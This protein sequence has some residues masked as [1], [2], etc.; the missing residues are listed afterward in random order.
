MN[1]NEII[2]KFLEYQID[3]IKYET[4]KSYT[5][6]K[7]SNK[8]PKISYN[9]VKDETGSKFNIIIG[10]KYDKENNLPFNLEI[11]IRG[12]FETLNEFSDNE[13]LEI[14]VSNGTAILFPYL[15]SIITDI[16]SKS[17]FLPIIIPTINFSKMIHEDFQKNKK[18][19][20]LTSEFYENP[21]I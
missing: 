15:R 4:N 5:K 14:V 16:T 13:K 11:K 6:E 1:N 17:N 19:H 21:K 8:S 9:I 20:L 12:F 3:N 2:L 10:A 18:E 7:I